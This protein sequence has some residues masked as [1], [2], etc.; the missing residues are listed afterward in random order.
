MG[1]D[2]KIGYIRITTFNVNTEQELE[3]ALDNFDE[4]TKK[5]WELFLIYVITRR[6]IG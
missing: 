1:K 5:S 2:D 3:D 4:K 6:V